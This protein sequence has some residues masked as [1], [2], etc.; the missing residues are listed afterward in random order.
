MPFHTIPHCSGMGQVFQAFH[1]VPP[2]RST[3]EH[4]PLL[5]MFLING[6]AISWSSCKQELVTLSTAEAEYVAATHTTKEVIWL[7]HLIHELFPAINKLITLHSDNQVAQKLAKTD[8]YHTWMKHIKK[9]YHFICEA[10]ANQTLC[11]QDCGTDDM[12]A[13]ILTKALPLWKVSAHTTV[14]GLHLP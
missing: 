12:L 4:L 2:L 11:L 1:S 3:V 5:Q 10:I 13:D 14:L 8:N 7:Q 6:G 9:R